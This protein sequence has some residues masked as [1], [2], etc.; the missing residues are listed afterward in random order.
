MSSF[1]NVH[2]WDGKNKSMLPAKDLLPSLY[3]GSVSDKQCRAE[4]IYKHYGPTMTADYRLGVILAELKDSASRLH[5]HMAGMQMAE[6]CVHCAAKDGGGC[7]SLFMADETDGVQMLMNLLVGDKLVQ[8]RNDGVECCF[9]G[10]RGCIFTYKPMF[11]LNYN[12]KK[13]HD[14]AS[15]GDLARL[16]KLTGQLL[17]KQHEAEQRLLEI[18]QAAAL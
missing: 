2:S 18:I 13:I 4:E 6:L 9:L 16:E 1:T 15:V 3:Y 8:V 12:C 11:C 17:G 10:E 7:C 5:S 14:A